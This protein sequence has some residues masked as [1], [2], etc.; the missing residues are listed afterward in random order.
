MS[1]AWWVA[2]V[3]D[4]GDEL[5]AV[6]A[7]HVRFGKGSTKAA[8]VKA[9]RLGPRI[10]QSWVSPGRVEWGRRGSIVVREAWCATGDRSVVWKRAGHRAR[11]L[12]GRRSWPR[13][14]DKRLDGHQPRAVRRTRSSNSRPTTTNAPKSRNCRARQSKETSVRRFSSGVCPQKAKLDAWT[15]NALRVNPAIV[16]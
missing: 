15:E 12:G 2:T 5:T 10:S 1:P 14:L 11:L 3:P 4:T 13:R 6:V 8:G 7:D 9:G 16:D